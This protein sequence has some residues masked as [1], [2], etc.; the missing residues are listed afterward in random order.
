[1]RVRRWIACAVVALQVSCSSS[2]KSGGIGGAGTGTGGSSAGT[3][4]AFTGGGG[5]APGAG[6]MSAGTGG[7][8]TGGS[9][10]GIG[11]NAGRAAGGFA[12]G[13]AGGTAIGA[14]GGG[15]A[16][17]ALPYTILP[18]IPGPIDDTVMTAPA[19][20]LRLPYASTL[21]RFA[22]APDGSVVVLNRPNLIKYDPAIATAMWTTPFPPAAAGVG[23]FDPRDIAIDSQGN[24]YVI[25]SETVSTAPLT[26]NPNLVKYSSGGVLVWDK[27][28]S[29]AD[30]SFT[31]IIVTSN[32]QI[33]VTG[34]G[35]GQLPNQPATAKG[36]AFVVRYDSDGNM[37]SSF[38]S[39]TAPYNRAV[40]TFGL[41]RGANNGAIIN[42]SGIIGL[43]NTEGTLV[44]AS[45]T[46]TDPSVASSPDGSIVVSTTT[47]FSTTGRTFVRFNST[48]GTVATVQTLGERTVVLN[49]TE[50][51][52]WKGTFYLPS[53]MVATDDAVYMSGS[54][55]NTYVNGS[56]P[57]QN[58]TVTYL[59]KIDAATGKQ[60]W[61]HLY[62]DPVDK[63][64]IESSFIVLGLGAHGQ[65]I[66]NISS[67]GN[68]GLRRLNTVDGSFL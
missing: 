52:M 48:T 51:A 45:T 33:V 41:G 20:G 46:T 39:T 19:N 4:G 37:L 44:W 53:L 26:M 54:Y 13:A 6:G 14:A 9:F 24:I 40:R 29:A 65:L 35:A 43:A 62:G 23:R 36:G 31:N 21:V 7:T 50:G 59:V 8:P 1:M 67:S 58:N 22:T 61:A 15:G 10:S 56:N 28:L 49:A 5:A 27:V 3:G 64:Y 17:G 11:G 2:S 63:S 30:V 68:G 47:R 34:S 16:G 60:V 25:G 55:M 32:D 38:Q 42:F 66:V 57:K 12:G 18:E